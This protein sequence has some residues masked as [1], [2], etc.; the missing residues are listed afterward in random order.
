MPFD[1]SPRA[2]RDGRNADRGEQLIRSFDSK[3]SFTTKDTKNTKSKHLKPF[4]SF[5]PLWLKTFG[6]LTIGWVGP[7]LMGI[8]IAAFG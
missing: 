3:G 1:I 4:M 7:A 2:A 8:L 6:T 5:V